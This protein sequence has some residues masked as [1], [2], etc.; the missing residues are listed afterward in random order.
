MNFLRQVR[1]LDLYNISDTAYT[2]ALKKICQ[3]LVE[4]DETLLQENILKRATNSE[5]P[6]HNRCG[7]PYEGSYEVAR[8]EFF[9]GG[10]YS[11]SERTLSHLTIHSAIFQ[12]FFG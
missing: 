11:T 6:L 8:G 7:R 1:P 10:I 2:D 9:I 3:T 12:A 5:I 4:I